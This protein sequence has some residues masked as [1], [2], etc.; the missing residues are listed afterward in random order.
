MARIDMFLRNLG[1]VAVCAAGLTLATPPS[2]GAQEQP[3][4]SVPR[5][6]PIPD[7]DFP[8]LI[9]DVGLV[10]TAKPVSDMIKGWKK[11]Q[12]IVVFPGLH[13][14]RMSWLQAAVP[15][16]KLVAVRTEAEALKEIVDAD[17]QIGGTCLH[18]LIEAG[19]KLNWVHSPH[20]GLERCVVGEGVPQRFKN[21]EVIVSSSKKLASPV[22]AQHI[23]GM[24]LA[25]S[26][27]IDLYSR[28]NAEGRFNLK[29]GTPGAVP[30]GR[31]RDLRGKTMLIV[32]L[33]G[34]GTYVAK[35]AQAMGMKI[36]A[37]RYTSTQ[38][39]DFVDHVGLPDELPKL[40]GEADVVVV[41]VPITP[42]TTNM[43]NADF[44]SRMKKGAFM[45]NG[46]HGEVLV[47]KDLQ[48]ALESGH[49]GGAA[50]ANTIPAH[51]PDNDP[52]YRTPNLLISAHQMGS[53]DDGLTLV[54]SDDNENAWLLI[55]E[56]LKRYVA[57]GK[58]YNVID[59]QRLY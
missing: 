19:K 32:G 9:R 30:L 2:H 38:G 46:T 23:M 4:T 40:L 58:I 25:L 28:M 15:G 7:G 14:G 5:S 56:N 44:F 17:A 16:I 12:K 33:G 31:L 26:R 42:Q 48:D 39:P 41:T 21:G 29:R 1:I 37:V 51:L 53:V 11:P 45:I 8:K 3:T 27:G 52:A 20:G 57:G 49:L 34:N 10:E 24:T 47:L 13:Q 35:Y 59:P 43:L 54:G 50:T 22:I 18:S 36:T 6:G 55:R